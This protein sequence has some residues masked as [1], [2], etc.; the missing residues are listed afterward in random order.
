M[1]WPKEVLWMY[2]CVVAAANVHFGVVP[3][4]ALWPH[5]KYPRRPEP[6]AT[7]ARF[8]G[9]M[10]RSAA[11]RRSLRPGCPWI[12]HLLLAAGCES[13]TSSASSTSAVS[14]VPGV[15]SSSLGTGLQSLRVRERRR[16]QH[17]NLTLLF[18]GQVLQ[19]STAGRA[20]L[21]SPSP[22]WKICSNQAFDEPR[23][24]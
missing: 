16:T 18:F 12:H 5:R 10:L 2:A 8:S 1:F 6:P 7:D 11:S 17:C 4:P 21:Y 15:P 13:D 3:W 19:P 14:S 9:F 20:A 22:T 24:S 23:A